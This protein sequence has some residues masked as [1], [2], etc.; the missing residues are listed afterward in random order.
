MPGVV[1]VPTTLTQASLPFDD[2]A[3]RIKLLGPPENAF[4]VLT[5][6]AASIT[7]NVRLVAVGDVVPTL[8]TPVPELYPGTTR[9]VPDAARVKK[10]G[11]AE[12]P[13]SVSAKLLP[14]T[15]VG[16]AIDVIGAAWFGVT[17]S[18]CSMN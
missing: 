7:P 5:L 8:A 3:L 4:D 6:P 15:A 11:V 13:A 10:P 2:A 18:N 14:L 16:R 17:G 1:A 9:L 12:L